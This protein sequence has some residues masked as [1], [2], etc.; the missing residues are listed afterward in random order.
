MLHNDL[1]DTS[2]PR[3]LVHS[4]TVVDLVPQIKK[5]MF[6]PTVGRLILPRDV[7]IAMMNDL[8]DKGLKMVL[9]GY[10]T[11]PVEPEEILKEIDQYHHPFN[12]WLVFDS[13]FDLTHYLAMQTDV[14]HVIDRIRPLAFGSRNLHV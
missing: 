8:S 12:E 10:T 2:P 6:M 3:C 4:S 9:F 11:D 5:K 14:R 13:T 7:D 1:D